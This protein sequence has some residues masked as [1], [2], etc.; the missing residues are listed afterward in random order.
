M[1]REIIS[2]L[3]DLFMGKSSPL[4]KYNKSRTEMGNAHA[5]AKFSSLIS[6]LSSLI[7]QCYTRRW[8]LEL[9]EELPP[10]LTII[11]KGKKVR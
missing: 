9:S 1:S 3:I 8:T 6:A 5:P 4:Y 10:P 2:K 11:R 7:R